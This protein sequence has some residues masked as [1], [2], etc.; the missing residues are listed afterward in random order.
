LANS[1]GVDLD[2]AFEEVMAKY[3]QRDAKRWK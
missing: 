2:S 3:Q 1:T